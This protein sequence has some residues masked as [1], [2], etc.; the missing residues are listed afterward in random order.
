M[1]KKWVLRYEYGFNRLS[2]SSI[3]DAEKFMDE[4]FPGFY[5]EGIPSKLIDH[6]ILCLIKNIGFFT[7]DGL[8]EFLETLNK[9]ERE[10]FNSI[11]VKKYL[12]DWGHEI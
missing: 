10:Q 1:K 5:V 6:G 12:I 8:D 3:E 4:N 11:V 7:E 2:R 9:D